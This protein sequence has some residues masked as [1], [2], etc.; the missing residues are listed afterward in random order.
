MNIIFTKNE[1]VWK[2]KEEKTFQIKKKKCKSCGGR[3]IYRSLGKNSFHGC[4]KCKKKYKLKEFKKNVEVI[5]K[6][7]TKKQFYLLKV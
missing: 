4:I 5:T 7:K 3:V 1:K 2:G 6:T